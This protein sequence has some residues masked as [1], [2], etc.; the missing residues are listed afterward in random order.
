VEISIWKELIFFET[1]APM[2]Q[3]TTIRLMFVLEILLGLKPM[4]GNFTC[5]FLHVNLEE[6]KKVYINVPMGFAQYGKNGK[7]KFLKLKKTLYG[8]CQSCRASWKY[9]TVKFEEC[10]LEKSKFDPCIFIGPDVICVVYIDNLIF[11]S[12]ETPVINPVAMELPELGL[13]LSKKS[14]QLVSLGL[15]WVMMHHLVYLK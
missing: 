2:I 8:L 3:W 1:Y 15:H 12:K 7:K 13:I 5:A 6:N 14:M 11:G 10:A 4:Q 9:I